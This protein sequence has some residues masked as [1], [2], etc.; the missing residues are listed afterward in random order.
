MIEAYAASARDLNYNKKAKRERDLNI[1]IEEAERLNML[2]NDILLLSKMQSKTIELNIEVFNITLLITEILERFKIYENEGYIFEFNSKD[3]YF[4]KAD[5]KHIERVIYNLIINAINY[6][7]D[8]KKIEIILKKD[9][10][11]LTTIIKDNGPGIK[12]KDKKLV[13]NKYYRINKKHRRNNI[14][15]GLGLSIVKE[16]LEAL[17]F[18]YG[19][20]SKHN[21]GSSF[22]FKCNIEEQ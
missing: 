1:I 3:N 16:I 6:V 17:N 4:I 9:N 20:E 7:G 11:L 15:T 2:V 14:G 13:W 8:D 10:N 22:Y 21:H 18:E 19:I 5:K 12:D